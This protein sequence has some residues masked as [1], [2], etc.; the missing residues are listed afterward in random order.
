MSAV[1]SPL[2]LWRAAHT[3]P[4]CEKKIAE[5]CERDGLEVCLPLYPSIKKYH[6]K[7]VEF[8]KPLF[9]GYVFFRA[10]AGQCTRLSQ[11]DHVARVLTPPDEAEFA[12]QLEDILRALATRREI[13]LAPEVVDGMRVHI[14]RGP[15]RGLEGMV[16]RRSGLLEVY[17]RLDFIGQSAAV[18]VQADEVEAV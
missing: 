12:T 7:T 2:V 14:V 13:R 10:T 17:L 3:G 16:E 1:D 9:P 11:N 8:T 5:F 18:R 4:R 6:G 15:L